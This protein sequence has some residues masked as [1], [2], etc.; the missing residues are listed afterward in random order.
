MPP[1]FA[2]AAATASVTDASS[3]MSPTIGSAVPPAASI[4][5]AAV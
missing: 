5:S 1:N 2:T 4:A 3:R